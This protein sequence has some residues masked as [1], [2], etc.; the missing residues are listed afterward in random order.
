MSELVPVRIPARAVIVLALMI[1]ACASDPD[2]SSSGSYSSGCSSGGSY[3]GGSSSCGSGG[4]S[5][6]SS[7]SGYSGSGPDRP[8]A[9]AQPYVASDAP[10]LDR[11]KIPQAATTADVTIQ[12]GSPVRPTD[13]L[14][15]RLL[16]KY[17]LALGSDN[18]G[19]GN[20][21]YISYSFELGNDSGKRTMALAAESKTVYNADGSSTKMAHGLGFCTWDN[22]RAKMS[23]GVSVSLADPYT[24]AVGFFRDGR[25]YGPWSFAYEDLSKAGTQKTNYIAEYQYN[26][27]NG[28]LRFYD[29]DGYITEQTWTVGGVRHG[30]SYSWSADGSFSSTYVGGKDSGACAQWNTSGQLIKR[31][32]AFDGKYYGRTEF[33]Y[34]GATYPYVTR[35]FDF[36]PNRGWAAYYSAEGKLVYQAWVEDGA[37]NGPYAAYWPSGKLRWT[38]ELTK[39]NNHGVFKRFT[40]DGWSDFETT[41]A[42][43]VQTGPVRWFHKDGKVKEEGTFVAGKRQGTF[44]TYS[45]SGTLASQVEWDSD[46]AT[47]YTYYDEQG[48]VTRSY[49]PGEVP[50]EK[51][52]A[53]GWNWIDNGEF[54]T[55]QFTDRAIAF[56]G[57][58]GNALLF[59]GQQGIFGADTSDTWKFDGASWQKAAPRMTPGARGNAALY[60]S[61]VNKRLTM[62]GGS[63]MDVND[64]FAFEDRADFWEWKGE[65]WVPRVDLAIGMPTGI[66]ATRTAFDTDRGVL[67]ALAHPPEDKTSLRLFEFD[68][69]NWKDVAAPPVEGTQTAFLCWDPVA[70]RVLVY[71][72]FQ[73]E[74]WDQ[75]EQGW[76][77]DGKAWEAS[78][79]PTIVPGSENHISSPFADETR[80]LLWAFSDRKLCCWD[81]KVWKTY[82]SPE[83]LSAQA[84]GAVDPKT[85]KLLVHFAQADDDTTRNASWWFDPAQGKTN[86]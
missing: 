21:P 73:G 23:A 40:E 61:T 35:Y 25:M 18:R 6:G 24:Y 71:Q 39:G 37:K 26:Q 67:V 8:A 51:R 75:Y 57:E 81:G 63:H 50:P 54:G 27:A 41:Y 53:A 7:S 29:Q 74:D 62:L 28:E 20:D 85:G 64:E 60:Y 36:G 3:S 42:N 22:A 58:T 32:N 12:Y 31:G 34:P 15:E 11:S 30:A 38:G 86:E 79:T 72:G 45:E 13:N 4:S 76:S 2:Y 46:V 14:W 78:T 43:G 59:G 9:P 10:E 49:S 33:W 84:F 83:S 80:K 1:L 16:S 66:S 47:H 65:S 55:Q 70:R 44:K 82:E 5:S 77:W 68:G 52:L 19:N 48:Q 69:E 17:S 56:D